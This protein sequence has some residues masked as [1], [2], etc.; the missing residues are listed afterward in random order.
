[1]HKYALINGQAYII[2][3]LNTENGLD[4]WIQQILQ[5]C[6]MRKR[7]SMGK[8]NNMCFSAI[9][10]NTEISV[11]DWSDP[12]K[13]IITRKSIVEIIS[14]SFQG[15]ERDIMK[16]CKS[17]IASALEGA[18]KNMEKESHGLPTKLKIMQLRNGTELSRI[19]VKGSQMMI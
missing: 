6:G 2:L 19:I 13:S 9:D 7:K 11:E 18:I 17:A 5:D 16:S 15:Q 14:F 12:Q 3:D 8:K 10:F 1:M 4:A